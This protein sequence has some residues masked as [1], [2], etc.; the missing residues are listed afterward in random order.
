MRC[1]L[2]ILIGAF[3]LAAQTTF[4][5]ASVHPSAP[6]NGGRIRVG[7]QGGPGRG[8]PGRMTCNNADLLMLVTMAY[9][10]RRYQVSAPDWM[11]TE[12]YDITA[13]VPE[14]A[15]KEQ[16][17]VMLQKLLAERFKMAIHRGKK[18]MPVYQVVVGKNGP[19]LK[20][21]EDLPPEAPGQP[22]P[23]GPPK[24]DANGFP[25]LPPGRR[26]INMMMN[27]KARMVSS[28]MTMEQFA[29]F[30]S[31]QVDRPVTDG[32]G[33]KGKYDISIYW[34]TDRMLPMGPNPSGEARPETDNGPNIFAA[35][36]EQL[37]LRLEGKKGAVEVLVVDHA[38]KVPVEN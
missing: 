28:G 1:A 18:E 15:T 31:N 33:L 25:M 16:A 9:D 34:A 21:A 32:T 22:L 35:V 19:K 20:E 10:L 8:D 38:E 30:L 12:R 37:G 29:N 23:P 27:G 26:S 7:C 3:A 11:S 13:T 14:G 2:L 6:P 17:A 4:E 5:V 24:L 36:Q